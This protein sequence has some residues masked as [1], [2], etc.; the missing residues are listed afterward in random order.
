M[1]KK[2]V[3]V[4]V[5]PSGAGKSTFID[6][7]DS[8]DYV[9][10]TSQPMVDELN[11]RGLPVNHDTIF[12]LSQE[13]YV[14]DPFW[15]VRLIQKVLKGKDFLIVDGSRRLPEV[16][17]LKELFQTIIIAI[18]SPPEVRFERLKKRTKIFLDTVDEFIKLECDEQTTM[19]V[20][21]LVKIADF[22]V[23]NDVSNKVSLQKLR[24]EGRLLGLFLK[25]FV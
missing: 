10:V 8:L 22:V 18:V 7:M 15:Q 14:E 6:A 5:G 12:E 3:V 19:D 25:V 24:E 2:V 9:Y 1:K 4:I 16:R 11:R 13:W 21:A 23:Q 20:K 17:R